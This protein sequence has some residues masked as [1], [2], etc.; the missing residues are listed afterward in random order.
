MVYDKKLPRFT[1][2]GHFNM[3]EISL[4]DKISVLN[5]KIEQLEKKVAYYE[6]NEKRFEF[7]R[8]LLEAVEQAV[9][10]TD[11]NGSITFWNRYAEKL[12]GWKAWEVYG[13]NIID[14][15]PSKKLLE[16]AGDIM[17]TV[18]KGKTWSGEFQV[19]QKSGSEFEASVSLS[20]V[21][22]ENGEVD[23]LIGI[24]KD[25][26]RKKSYEERIVR[27]E[28]EKAA[29]L[30]GLGDIIIEYVDPDMKIIWT[31]AAM[32]E[33]FLIGN[34]E[35][36]GRY[37]YEV[38]QNINAPCPGCTAVKAIQTGKYEEG[39]VTTPNGDIFLVRSNPV[40]DPADNG[41]IV[42]VIH[43]AMNISKRKKA[44]EALKKNEA[45]L[46]GILNQM[47][48]IVFIK[49]MEGKY[50]LVN[51][52]WEQILNLKSEEV[53]GKR[54]VEILPE[55]PGQRFESLDRQIIDTLEPVEFEESLLLNNKQ[56]TY[57]TYMSPVFNS[58][59][60]A[61]AIA[62]VST[63][64]TDRKKEEEERKNLEI[65][66]RKKQKM[67][68]LGTMAGGIAH[69]FN[70]ILFPIIGFAEMTLEE[71]SGE[72]QAS[73]NIKEI[74][75]AT[76][77]A[78]DVVSQI[79]SFSREIPRDQTPFLLQDV[80]N[81]S[82]SLL[83]AS[84]PKNID[85]RLEVDSGCPAILGDATEFHQVI[86]NLCMNAYHAMENEGG[87]LIIR[88]N[89]VTLSIKD[90]DKTTLSQGRYV[91]L[92]VSD[93][94][95]GMKPEVL[96]H[97]F[98]PYFS[99]KEVGKGTGLGMA[100]VFGIVKSHGGD[101]RIFS[102]P[103][104]GTDVKIYLPPVEIQPEEIEIVHN[105]IVLGGSEHILLVDDEAQI[106]K[107]EKLML[108]K[109]GYRVTAMTDSEKALRSFTANPYEF[110]LIITDLTMPV[111]PGDRLSH[112]MLAIRDDIPII[113]CTGY[114]EK[115]K[116]K[117]NRELGVQDVIIKPMRVKEVAS[118]VRKVLDNH[119]RKTDRFYRSEK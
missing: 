21:F 100:V 94:G 36:E 18:Y 69:D 6:N 102:R 92:S 5:Q 68:A 43:M 71:F 67:E 66:L 3:S 106:T 79:L 75:K 37:C 39:E 81:E 117:T 119:L 9:I 84:I 65:R 27:S 29:I 38:V 58:N 40:R 83:R 103:G 59:G 76:R 85:I 111:I 107:M 115:L 15:T 12:Y 48:A 87:N 50:L 17:K 19:K 42:G 20:P 96:E 60:N 14:V 11:R 33:H 45:M 62:G 63:D 56:R 116:G 22:D 95:C 110:D 53:I 1:M 28:R 108:E 70:N 113:L 54:P 47:P 109:L 8:Q 80:L 10:A 4:K 61:L 73:D 7:H 74:L 32:N 88:L 99:T 57:I 82:M 112:K 25:I 13:N 114:R 35:L 101:I 34:E 55:D 23:G 30:N 78:K 44:E 89:M 64:I 26:S 86:V 16:E 51:R 41:K 49:D 90:M 24:S 72:S 98:D 52:K 104:A 77:R 105:G 91:M 2:K 93:N 46:R 31:N 97:I 118:I